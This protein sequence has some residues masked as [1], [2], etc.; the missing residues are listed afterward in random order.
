M[1]KQM[2]EFLCDLLDPNPKLWQKRIYKATD[3]GAWIDTKD[4]TV[5]LGSIV[6]GSHYDVKP[7]TITWPFTAIQFW[8]TL[9]QIEKGADQIWNETHGCEECASRWGFCDDNGF[10][11]KGCDGMTP[12]HPDCETCN[13]N[14]VVI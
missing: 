6:E 12:V 4:D 1:N 10:E 2:R 3:C 11:V 8:D 9:E 5:T 7:I 13:G 14:G